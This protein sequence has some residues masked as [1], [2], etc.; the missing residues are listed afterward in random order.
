[1]WLI[2]S[3]IGRKL[4]MSITGVLLVL[5]LLFHSIMNF[6]SILSPYAYD[7]ICAFLG[8]NWYAIIGT[9]GLAA[10]FII[11]ILY[12]L[13]LSYQNLRA[14]GNNRY[15]VK[16]RQKGVSWASLNMLVLGIIILGFMGL[17]LFQFW[18]KMQLIELMHNMG[19]ATDAQL[20]ALAAKGSH[21]VQ[22]YFG[23]PI[24]SVLYIV[25]LSALW[26]HLTH[27]VWSMLHTLG[28]NNQTWLPRLKT[29][30]YILATIIIL[31]FMAVPICGLLK[32]GPLFSP[33]SMY[34]PFLN[35]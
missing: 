32:A 9:M 1:M 34:N 18:S 16:V 15:A 14:R 29:F 11:H 17:H 4:I 31:L 8:A 27:G 35:I 28:I 6:V 24:Y 23:Q 10:G 13:I 25:W 33:E 2:D 5:F 20:T 12:A 19:A 30:S 7:V 21:W 22:Y 3:S 26:F